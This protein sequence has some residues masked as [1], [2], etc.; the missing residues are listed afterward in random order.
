ML[1]RLHR[2]RVTVFNGE[3]GESNLLRTGRDDLAECGTRHLA[4]WLFLESDQ[5]LAFLKSTIR[6]FEKNC[7]NRCV[8]VLRMPKQPSEFFLPDTNVLVFRSITW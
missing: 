2:V 7:L 6:F 4:N 5:I 1:S 8:Q 3:V